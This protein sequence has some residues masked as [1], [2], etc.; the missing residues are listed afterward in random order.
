MTADSP[1]TCRGE[2][3]TKEHKEIFTSVEADTK[4]PVIRFSVRET[5]AFLYDP[6]VNAAASAP[7]KTGA[8]RSDAP[9]CVLRTFL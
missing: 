6:V 9:Y 5:T 7:R 8:Q 2:N 4:K 3:F 1:R